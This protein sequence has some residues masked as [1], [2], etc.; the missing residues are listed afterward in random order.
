MPVSI[1]LL[2]AINVGTT[3]RIRKEALRDAFVAA[4]Y[5][6]AVTYIQSGNVL[7]GTDEPPRVSEARIR[8]QLQDDLGL[9]IDVLVRTADELARIAMA[10]PFSARTEDLTRL[11]VFFLSEPLPEAALHALRARSFGSDEWTAAGRE[12]YV[13]YPNGAGGGKFSLKAV[14]TARNWNVIE[15]LVELARAHG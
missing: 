7:F 11:H 12:V 13:Y 14:A 5:P 8:K 15:K 9:T 2:R 10:H 6:D 3:N 1:A 4:G